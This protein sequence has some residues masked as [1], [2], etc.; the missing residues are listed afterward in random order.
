MRY[1]VRHIAAA[2]VLLGCASAVQGQTFEAVG[3]RAAGMGGAF[4]GVADD[5]SAAYWNPAGLALGNVFSI[6]VDL[7]TS[8]SDPAAMEGARKGSGFLFAMGMPALG[9]S[10]YQIRSTVLADLVSPTDTV[11]VDTLVTH[12]TGATVLQSIGHRLTVAGTAK[13]VSG[14]ASSTL[15]TGGSRETLLDLASELGGRQSTKFDADLGVMTTGSFFK[16]GLTIRN[17]LN[18]EFETPAGNTIALQ[19]QARTGIAFL[20]SQGWAVDA[21][22]DLTTTH[23]SLGDERNIAI[24]T[25]GRIGRKVM[26][27]TGL[28]FNTTGLSRTAPAAGA[29]YRVAGALF[30][31]GQITRG[32]ERADRGWGI[33]ARL[34]Y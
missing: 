8:K 4:V 14:T 1:Y 23:G 27:R 20:V 26:A 19:R 16:I 15:S 3:T 24:G 25:E 11:R 31:D 13:L 9:L 6:V 29:S 7:G 21:D 5:A 2:L 18:P 10:Y 33:S 32:S 34:V 12:H 30:V 17:L 22:F 28:R